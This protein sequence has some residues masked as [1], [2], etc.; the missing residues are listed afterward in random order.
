MSLVVL[1]LALIGRLAGVVLFSPIFILPGLAIAALGVWLGQ[2]YMR[3]QLSVK[4]EV[5]TAKAP[6]LGVVGGAIAG[7]RKSSI[8]SY[9][10]VFTLFHAASIRAYGAQDA[11]KKE[12]LTRINRYLRAA[13]V[14]YNLN[15]RVLLSRKVTRDTHWVLYVDGWEPA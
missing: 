2:V 5:S 6:V 15:R 11:I 3:A 14:S 13:R 1:T 7:L 4:R 10:S 9:I 8:K 12:T